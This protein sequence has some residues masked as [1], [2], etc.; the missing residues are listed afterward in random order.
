MSAVA[1][2]NFF[3]PDS[4]EDKVPQ[5]LVLRQFPDHPIPLV[6]DLAL[7]REMG[8]E[9]PRK[10]REII[11]RNRFRLAQLGPRPVRGAVAAPY[12]RRGA[13]GQFT[14]DP[15]DGYWL[16]REQATWLYSRSRT[17]RA[18]EFLDEL[19]RVFEAWGKGETRRAPEQAAGVIPPALT[20]DREGRVEQIES[21]IYEKLTFRRSKLN[22]RIFFPTSSEIPMEVV[23]EKD[24]IAF[25][26]G[27]KPMFINGL[28]RKPQPPD[29]PPLLGA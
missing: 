7:A 11:E 1:R 27:S 5:T 2:G 12:A 19:V 15:D 16:N 22:P 28:K 20:Y 4:W 18:K 13:N 23:S 3:V 29:S 21:Q 17:V 26:D 6:H 8:Y 14:D 25:A 24:A 10:I 9:R